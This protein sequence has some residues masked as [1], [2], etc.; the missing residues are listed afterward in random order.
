MTSEEA[1]QELQRARA[2]VAYAVGEEAMARELF[3]VEHEETERK[4]SEYLAAQRAEKAAER[5][6]DR[7]CAHER[8]EAYTP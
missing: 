8:G 4:G 1:W 5:E 7:A 3:G 6:Y 2:R